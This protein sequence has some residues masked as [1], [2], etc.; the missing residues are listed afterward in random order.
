MKLAYLLYRVHEG[1]HGHK[2]VFV[3]VAT[4]IYIGKSENVMELLFG[5]AVAGLLETFEEFLL[6]SHRS[7]E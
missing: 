4:A 7:G 1:A 5:E 6:L 3:Q 2:L